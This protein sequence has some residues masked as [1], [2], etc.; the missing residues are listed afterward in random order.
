M[1]TM[2]N[3]GNVNAYSKYESKMSSFNEMVHPFVDN[4]IYEHGESVYLISHESF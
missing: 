2:I 3:M 1:S 4:I